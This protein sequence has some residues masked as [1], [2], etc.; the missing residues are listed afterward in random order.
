M[1]IIDKM[2]SFLSGDDNR[3]AE[4]ERVVEETLRQYSR[5]ERMIYYIN[6]YE[7][8]IFH[9]EVA[10]WP[11]QKKIDFILY[12]LDTTFAYQEVNRHH[13][14]RHQFH[15]NQT[16]E[17]YVSHLLS[18]KIEL[19]ESDIQ[20]LL[21]ACARKSDWNWFHLFYRGVP[22]LLGKIVLKYNDIPLSESV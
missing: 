16:R 18:T 6:V 22:A 14:D 1:S 10:K 9:S 15:L 17:G 3:I 7:T 11:D 2:K 4:Y 8:D 21:Q 13:S 19:E 20:N 5:P 12:C